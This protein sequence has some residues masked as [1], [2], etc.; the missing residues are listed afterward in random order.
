MNCPVPK[1][2]VACFD[3]VL[4]RREI[5]DAVAAI[6]REFVAEAVGAGAAAQ[7]VA[8]ALPHQAVLATAAVQRIPRATADQQVHPAPAI[9]VVAPALA[10]QGIRP[11]AGADERIVAGLPEDRV[12]PGI[13][14]RA[15][16][17]MDGHGGRDQAGRDDVVPD[18]ALEES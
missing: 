12:R 11:G 10:D 17:G 16:A 5:D 14:R 13:G 8:A 3:E 4:A 1:G 18:R 9:E 15:A 7:A 6:L 2:A